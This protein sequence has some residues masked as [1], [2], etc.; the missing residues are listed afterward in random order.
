MLSDLRLVGGMWGIFSQQIWQK[1]LYCTGRRR[2][3]PKL[4][5]KNQS[6]VRHM[7]VRC[8][9]RHVSMQHRSMPRRHVK[10]W[11]W[12]S[13]RPHASL[14]NKFLRGFWG[15]S[16]L[17]APWWEFC[18][19]V[20]GLVHVS[21]VTTAR[22]N[23]DSD[24]EVTCGGTHRLV[25]FMWQNH[26]NPIIRIKAGLGFPFIRRLW[27]KAPNANG[28]FLF[29]CF[30]WQDLECILH[31]QCMWQIGFAQQNVEYN[32]ILVLNFMENS[33]IFNCSNIE[34]EF[35]NDHIMFYFLAQASFHS[36]LDYWILCFIS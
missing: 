21:L 24:L 36:V 31:F 5:G 26:T 17:R 2:N 7:H 11:S 20:Y 13:P 23:A 25:D 19:C 30:F 33:K 28:V 1:K 29:I 14:C 15:S 34:I 32:L 4:P 22:W 16:K 35:F 3:F 10:S 27:W 8:N 12:R 18:V 6:G 9:T